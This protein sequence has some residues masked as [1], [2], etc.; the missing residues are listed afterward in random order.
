VRIRQPRV[1]RSAE[2]G[3]SRK[4]AKLVNLARR[5]KQFDDSPTMKNDRAFHRPGSLKK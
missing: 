5:R 1:E 3:K 4:Q 2:I